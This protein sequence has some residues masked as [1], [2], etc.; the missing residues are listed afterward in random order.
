MVTACTAKCPVRV[1]WLD[2][3]PSGGFAAVAVAI[4]E[5]AGVIHMKPWPVWCAF[6]DGSVA[7]RSELQ[8]Y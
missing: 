7:S 2:L 1:S 4:I 6:L 5:G 3:L 8:G